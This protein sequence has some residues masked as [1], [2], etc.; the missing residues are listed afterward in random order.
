MPT[1]EFKNTETDEVFEKFMSMSSLDTYL[2]E[3]PHIIRH[4]QG[5]TPPLVSGNAPKPADGFRDI[6]KVIKGR[7]GKNNTVNT[8]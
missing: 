7:S 3:N 1:Y 5:S 6:L 2:E 8:F 4:H